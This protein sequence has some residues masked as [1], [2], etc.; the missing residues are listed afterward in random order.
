MAEPRKKCKERECVREALWGSIYCWHHLQSKGDSEISKWRM[1]VLNNKEVL[2]NANLEYAD[3]SQDAYSKDGSAD[4]DF[5]KAVITDANLACANLSGLNMYAATIS[6]GLNCVDFT[7]ANL[8]QA[9]LTSSKLWNAKLVNTDLLGT[10]FSGSDLRDADLQ[11]CKLGETDFSRCSLRSAKLNGAC[12]SGSKFQQADLN[13]AE[14]RDALIL[15]SNFENS[16]LESADFENTSLLASDFRGAILGG[17]KLQ[18]ASLLMANF[19]NAGIG[20]ITFRKSVRLPASITKILSKFH[21]FPKMPREFREFLDRIKCPTVWKGARVDSIASCD[22]LIRK[23]IQDEVWLEAKLEDARNSRLSQ[24]WMWIWGMSCGY[25]SYA[26]LWLFWCVAIIF[27]FGLI[28][29]LGWNY[30]FTDIS[31]VGPERFG[32]AMYGS[33]VTFIP[34]TMENLS[35]RGLLGKLIML[36][37]GISGY[38]MLAGLISIFANRI[39]RL[40]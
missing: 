13:M 1:L 2:T 27:A 26:S 36:T 38:V 9:E 4:V 8:S 32:N 16:N 35:P 25:G 28:Y 31:R 30:L 37:Q 24:F 20:N 40:S 29:F 6:G 10:N 11:N 5:S 33:I 17:T 39:A 14:I 19:Q 15:C 23:L 18:G 34:M 12:G 3:L 7:N 22:P 21:W